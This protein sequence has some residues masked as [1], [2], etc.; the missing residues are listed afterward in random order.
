MKGFLGLGLRLG[1]GDGWDS[2]DE[3]KKEKGDE[4]GSGLKR[5]ATRTAE[6][7]SW[8]VSRPIANG[9][10]SIFGTSHVLWSRSF[11]IALGCSRTR[12]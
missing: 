12:C 1:L 5:F 9:N 8:T 7:N 6:N 4:E 2:W 10:K 11:R 3:S